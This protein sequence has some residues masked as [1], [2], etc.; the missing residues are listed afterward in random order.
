[1]ELRLIEDNEVAQI[2]WYLN[3]LELELTR[4]CKNKPRR[5][6]E[7]SLQAELSGYCK[8]IKRE[9]RAPQ[10]AALHFLAASMGPARV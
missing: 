1:M 8:D 7:T 6:S 4:E 5:C 9:P 3:K 2:K 10:P